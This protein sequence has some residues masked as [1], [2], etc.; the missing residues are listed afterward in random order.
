MSH[1]HD[2]EGMMVGAVAGS[3]AGA[4]SRASPSLHDSSLGSTGLAWARDWR[5]VVAL[6]LLMAS[7][8]HDDR[9]ERPSSRETCNECDMNGLRAYCTRNDRGVGY[10]RQERRKEKRESKRKRKELKFTSRLSQCSQSF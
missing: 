8:H 10:I 6:L 5:R 3:L 7:R 2:A 1:S 4:Q 9:L